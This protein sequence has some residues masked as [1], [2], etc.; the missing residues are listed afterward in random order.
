M[1]AT[2]ALISSTPTTHTAL[3]SAA[4]DTVHRCH[5]LICICSAITPDSSEMSALSTPSDTTSA[6]EILRSVL[7]FL[8]L[9][10]RCRAHHCGLAETPLFTTFRRAGHQT[11]RGTP[12]PSTLNAGWRSS[13]CVTFSFQRIKGPSGGSNSGAAGKPAEQQEVSGAGFSD[14]R[15]TH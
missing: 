4:R 7:F 15:R 14:N 13:D 8:S 9:A 2:V 1:C 6:R 12:K 11:L 5:P 3:V 10:T